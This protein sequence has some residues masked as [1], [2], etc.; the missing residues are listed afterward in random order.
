MS[1]SAGYTRNFSLLHAMHIALNRMRNEI[2][3]EEKGKKTDYYRPSICRDPIRPGFPTRVPA[4]RVLDRYV[5][6]SREI[7]LGRQV[8]QVFTGH[9]IKTFL[10]MPRNIW[11]FPQWEKMSV[12]LVQPSIGYWQERI[13]KERQICRSMIMYRV[14]TECV[15]WEC[16]LR[17]WTE[18][19]I[20]EERIC[21]E[22]SV[23][24]L[25]NFVFLLVF[26]FVCPWFSTFI[27]IIS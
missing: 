18:A 6:L 15:D 24:E 20:D 13:R 3:W 26:H 2:I 25:N 16:G 27:W 12:G 1:S 22:K 14:W 4:L 23:S 9:K 7:Q 17:V 19:A 11:T 21:K 5:P 8:S 10:T